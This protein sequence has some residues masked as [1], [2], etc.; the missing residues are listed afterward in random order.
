MTLNPIK[1]FENLNVYCIENQKKITILPL[2]LTD[3]KRNKHVNL[4]YMQNPQD[5]NMKH[6][7]LIKDLSR[8][9]SSQLSKKER[10]KYFCDWYV[11][12]NY[13]NIFYNKTI[14]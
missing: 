1:K 10:K 2:R 13:V 5:D 9:L 7:A 11:I 14:L 8:L 6:F 4:L 12:K 3:M